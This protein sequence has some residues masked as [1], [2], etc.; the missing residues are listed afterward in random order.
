MEDIIMDV[1]LKLSIGM[2]RQTIINLMKILKMKVIG[3]TNLENI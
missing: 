1:R 3:L 2:E